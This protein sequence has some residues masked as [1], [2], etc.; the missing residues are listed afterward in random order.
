MASVFSK[1][2]ICRMVFEVTPDLYQRF[3]TTATHLGLS[4]RGL[5]LMCFEYWIKK[6]PPRQ[7]DD[8]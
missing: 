7:G 1:P 5:F 2:G 6:N 8:R 4:K 3:N